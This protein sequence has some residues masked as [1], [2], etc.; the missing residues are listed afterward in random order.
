MSDLPIPVRFKPVFGW[1]LLVLGLFVI[2]TSLLTG[3]L[4]LTVVG[5]VNSAAAVGFAT[6]PMFVVFADR[7]EVKNLL[8]MTLK[9]LP[10]RSL[11]DLRIEGSQVVV[12]HSPKPRRLG[13]A[14]VRTSDWEALRAAVD[15]AG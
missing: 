5:V 1:V 6:Q 13:G 8:G 2:G 4:V 9:T 3:N 10:I 15:R 7:V 14:L 11:Q 12:P